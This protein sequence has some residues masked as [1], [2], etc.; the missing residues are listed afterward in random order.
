MRHTKE[1]LLTVLL[2]CSPLFAQMSPRQQLHTALVLERQGQFDKAITITKEAIDSNQLSGIE[3]GRAYIMLGTACHEAGM[4]T[5]A[6]EAFESSLRMLERD[7]EYASDYAAALN[8][9]GALYGDIGQLDTAEAMWQKALHLRQQIGDHA[10]AARS[11]MNLAGLAL[12]QKRTHDAKNYVKRTSDEMR[13]AADLID[14]DLALFFETQGWLALA[15]GHPAAAVASF[16]HALE[17]CLTS[18]G[19]HHWLTGWEHMLRGKAYAQAGDISNA[20]ADMQQGLAILDDALGR[21]SPKYFAAEIAYS[22]VL[23]RAGSHAQAAQMRAAAEQDS[24]DFYGSKCLGC[25]INIA[26]YR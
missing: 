22:Q 25:T 6:Q 2:A 15:E 26:S 24:K 13:L 17:R 9:Y 3:L 4:F 19:E 12:A 21:K 1:I 16:Q 18:R 8:D 14:D 11:L 20:V 23:D 7:P 10:A 5:P